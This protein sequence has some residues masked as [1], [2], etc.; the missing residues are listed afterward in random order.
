MVFLL[1]QRRETRLFHTAREA[2]AEIRKTF[3]A[4]N[5]VGFYPYAVTSVENSLIMTITC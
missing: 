5:L 1:S 3:L 2:I 4:T